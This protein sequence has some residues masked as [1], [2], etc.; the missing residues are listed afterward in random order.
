VSSSFRAN[1][2]R[3]RDSGPAS[4]CELSRPLSLP[5]KVQ[6]YAGHFFGQ[7]C[8]G[9]SNLFKQYVLWRKAQQT[10]YSESAGLITMNEL[11]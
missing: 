3:T 2:A 1:D 8:W 7:V 5:S 11:R 6:P 9:G 4:D 10:R